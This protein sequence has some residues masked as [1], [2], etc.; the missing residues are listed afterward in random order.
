MVFRGPGIQANEGVPFSVPSDK[1]ALIHPRLQTEVA[2]LP[3]VG[4]EFGDGDVLFIL[5]V[6]YAQSSGETIGIVCD[7][8][9]GNG[10]LVF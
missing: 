1:N 10:D 9:K 5:A 3:D 7:Y 8:A 4:I 6:V 2:E